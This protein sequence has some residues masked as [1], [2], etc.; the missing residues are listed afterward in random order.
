MWHA[1]IALFQKLKFTYNYLA[2][3][4]LTHCIW[5]CRLEMHITEFFHKIC[6]EFSKRVH[7]INMSFINN[8]SWPE[9]SNEVFHI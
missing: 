6:K 2:L 1:V 9:T 3:Y 5:F 7:L 4:R 8:Q